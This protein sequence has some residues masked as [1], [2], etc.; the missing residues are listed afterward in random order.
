MLSK[1]V[2]FLYYSLIKCYFLL[3]NLFFAKNIIHKNSFLNAYSN[4]NYNN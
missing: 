2:N 4:L 3:I 1:F